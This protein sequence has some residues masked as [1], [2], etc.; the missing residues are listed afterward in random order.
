MKERKTFQ[1]LVSLFF[2]NYN[3]EKVA[4][5]K[6]NYNNFRTKKKEMLF[7]IICS[8]Q[9]LHKKMRAEKIQSGAE[10]CQAQVSYPLAF[11]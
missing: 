9:I 10:L 7:C 8:D 6:R 2:C 5:K 3:V 4:G 11:W 1:P